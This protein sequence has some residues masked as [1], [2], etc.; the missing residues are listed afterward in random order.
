MTEDDQVSIV[1]PE[2]DAIKAARK[3]LNAMVSG[4][5]YNTAHFPTR[6]TRE[7]GLDTQQSWARR[8]DEPLALVTTMPEYQPYNAITIIGWRIQVPSGCGWHGGNGTIVV[9]KYTGPKPVPMHSDVKVARVY[10]A[11]ILKWMWAAAGE[12]DAALNRIGSGGI[13]N[14]KRGA[15]QATLQAEHRRATGATTRTQRSATADTA[16]YGILVRKS[17]DKP[18]RWFPSMDEAQA[19]LKDR[20]GWAIDTVTG[21]LKA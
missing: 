3:A 19:W 14:N 7:L 5:Q 18:P 1:S 2:T 11:F 21:A 15:I 9:P 6:M 8:L 17:G 13:G 16:A 10:R 12:A 4:W 20:H